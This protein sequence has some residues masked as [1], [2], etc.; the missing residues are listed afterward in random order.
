[1]IAYAT[2]TV[3]TAEAAGSLGFFGQYGSLIILIALFALMYVVLILPQKKKEKKQ[4]EL[5]NAIVPGDSLTTIGGIT[6][7][8]IAVKEDEIMI[9]TGSDRTKIAIQKW[10][11]R[12]VVQKKTEE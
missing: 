4:R 7:K 10:A 6:G 3:D 11:V 12:D 2:S 8:V 5:I 9:E 1:M